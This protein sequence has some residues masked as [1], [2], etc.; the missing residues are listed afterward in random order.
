[1]KTNLVYLRKTHNLTQ[2]KLCNELKSFGCFISRSTYTRYETNSRSLPCEVLVKLALFY[3]T[4]T[5][6]ILGLTDKM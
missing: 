4:T 1:M 6:Y 3:N 2:Q 5:Y